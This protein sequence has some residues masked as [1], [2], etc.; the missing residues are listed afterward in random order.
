MSEPSY[1]EIR[2]RVEKRYKERQG[3]IVHLVVYL[4]INLL[5]WG[6]W[7]IIPQLGP[8]AWALMELA[9]DDIEFFVFPWPLVISIG[10]GLGLA[11]HYISYYYQHGPGAGQREAAIQRE[12]E[13]ELARRASYEKPKN[14]E[15]VRLTEDGELEAYSD[16]DISHAANRNR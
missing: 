4:I 1:E 5:I 7:W 9:P 16:D 11:S 6:L 14:D 15:R 10:W 3:F 12:V 13:Q 2:H 8:D